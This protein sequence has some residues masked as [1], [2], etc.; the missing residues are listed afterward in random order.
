VAKAPKA[1]VRLSSAFVGRGGTVA[2]Q[3]RATLLAGKAHQAG[4]VATSDSHR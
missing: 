2:A 3:H 4:L 1:P